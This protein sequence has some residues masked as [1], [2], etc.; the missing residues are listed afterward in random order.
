MARCA[1]TRR[2]HWSASANPTDTQHLGV[3]M[4]ASRT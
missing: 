4:S 1:P 2:L 3:R